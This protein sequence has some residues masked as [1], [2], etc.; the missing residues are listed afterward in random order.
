MAAADSSIGQQALESPDYDRLPDDAAGRGVLEME[1]A[2]AL[3]D[4]L[5]DLEDV[6]TDLEERTEKTGAE[7]TV[8]SFSRR[9]GDPGR[10]RQGLRNL[11]DS[12]ITYAGQ[13]TPRISVL[14]DKHR[15]EW[16]ISVRDRGIGIDPADAD[17]LFQVFDRLHSSEAS[18][19]TGTVP[20]PSETDTATG[21]T[22]DH[23]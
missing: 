1:Y 6:S 11:L 8:D 15:Q 17:R 21:T 16:T 10:L 3:N 13:Q 20:A 12:A 2:V 5:A 23:E 22:T 4:A 14:A 18:E 7:I 9:D 19:G